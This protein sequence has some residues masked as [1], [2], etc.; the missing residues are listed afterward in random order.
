MDEL[1]AEGDRVVA[2]IT[3]SGVSSGAHPRMPRPT[4]RAFRTEAVFVLT[5]GDGPI[6]EIRGVSDRRGRFLQPGWDWPTAD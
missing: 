2:R 5:V 4:G 6:S 3:Q 1:I